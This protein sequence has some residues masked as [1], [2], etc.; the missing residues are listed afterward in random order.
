MRSAARTAEADACL[1][2]GECR[3]VWACIRSI[4]SRPIGADFRA[5]A[6]GAEYG[7]RVERGYCFLC[8]TP[9]ENDPCP[10]CGRALSHPRPDPPRSVEASRD[11]L[12]TP[13]APLDARRRRSLVWVAGVGAVLL[14]V[15]VA[16][17]RSSFGV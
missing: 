4:P 3:P 9:A 6:T 16:V 14:V 8:D 13:D 1:V 7:G 11:P 2:D 17:L 15:I 5:G 12:L 10:G